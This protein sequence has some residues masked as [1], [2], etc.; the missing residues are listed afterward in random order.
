MK[1]A[2]V[3]KQK[4]INMGIA[5]VNKNIKY[6]K[7]NFFEIIFLCIV[8]TVV[9]LIIGVIL[10]PNSVKSLDQIN[11]DRRIQAIEYCVQEYVHLEYTREQCAVALEG[12]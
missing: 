10:M 4:L 6:I 7:E 11:V 5:T 8:M 2:Q 1:F 3:V 12:Q 9:I